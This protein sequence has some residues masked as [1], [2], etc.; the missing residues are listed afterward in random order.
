MTSFNAIEPAEPHRHLALKVAH[1]WRQEY[2]LRAFLVELLARIRPIKGEPACHPSE[3]CPATLQDDLEELLDRW[4]QHWF[5]SLASAPE[6]LELRDLANDA[7]LDR[8]GR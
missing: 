5:G 3:W 6:L 2:P 8:E 4:T 7:R 1:R